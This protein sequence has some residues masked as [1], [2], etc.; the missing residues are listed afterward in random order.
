[1]KV[2]ETFYHRDLG[3]VQVRRV[4][5]TE[6]VLVCS[7]RI[8]GRRNMFVLHPP[9]HPARWLARIPTYNEEHGS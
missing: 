1:M 9:K 5:D 7:E 2:G 4:I 8:H 3:E 6:H